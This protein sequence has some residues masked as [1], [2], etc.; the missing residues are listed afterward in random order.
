MLDGLTGTLTTFASTGPTFFKPFD[1]IH[2]KFTGSVRV[3]VGDVNGDKKDDLIVGEGLHGA[4]VK[5]FAGTADLTALDQTVLKDFKVGPAS[6]KG[7]VNITS[8]DT[9]HDGFA[10]I[11]VGRN[12][13]KPSQVEVFAGDNTASLIPATI[14]TPILPFDAD[15]SKP[16]YTFGV[17]VAVADVNGDGIADIIAAVGG[18][19]NSQVKFFDGITH[20]EITPTLPPMTAFPDFLDS[21]LWVAGSSPVPVAP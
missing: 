11:I 17:R 15:P 7:G 9:N 20:A 12:S 13:G 2:T 3:A 18:K 8:G 5:V 6:Y 19:A 21:S 1:T 4:E 14:G 10:D 16:K